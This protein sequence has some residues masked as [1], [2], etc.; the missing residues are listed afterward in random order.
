MC[1][2]DETAPKSTGCCEGPTELHTG[3]VLF[4]SEQ[5]LPGHLELSTNRALALG[6]VRS[7]CCGSCDS[8]GAPAPGK[9][10][11]APGTRSQERSAAVAMT[12]LQ[13]KQGDRKGQQSHGLFASQLRHAGDPWRGAGPAPEQT[14]P[15]LLSAP[16][17]GKAAGISARRARCGAVQEGKMPQCDTSSAAPR[18][19]AWG[20]VRDGCRR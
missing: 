17:S 19:G 1:V 9:R 8:S 12:P 3:F 16:A 15:C 4:L 2:S 20:Q 14:A 6:H 10:L 11:R 5:N 18:D 13:T 7:W